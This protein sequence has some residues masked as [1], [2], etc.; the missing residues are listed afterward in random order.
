VIKTRSPVQKEQRGLGPHD[1]SVG[2]ETGALHIKIE[3]LSI[4]V[5]KHDPPTL[6]VGILLQPLVLSRV[7]K[8]PNE[9]NRIIAGPGDLGDTWTHARRRGRPKMRCAPPAD[10]L[11]RENLRL[12][13]RLRYADNPDC[14]TVSSGRTPQSEDHRASKEKSR[15]SRGCPVP[16]SVLLAGECTRCRRLERG[17]SSSWRARGIATPFRSERE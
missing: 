3:A 10:E 9:R 11:A 6:R 2:N 15:L 13:S 17:V 5:S 7:R 14:H 4:D 12:C 1:G 8:R 16:V